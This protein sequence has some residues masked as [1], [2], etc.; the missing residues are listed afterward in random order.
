MPVNIL[1]KLRKAFVG[2]QGIVDS[3]DV[4]VNNTDLVGVL[5]GATNNQTALN[6]LDGTGIGAEIFTFTGAYSAQSTNIDEWFGGKQLVRMRCTSRGSSPTGSL[7]FDLPGTSALNTAFNQLVARGI[8]ERIEFNIEYTGATDSFVNI[9]PRVS[10]SPQ[11]MGITN[12]IVRSGVVATLEITRS[13]GTISSYIFTSISQIAAPGTGTFDALKLINP[14]TTIWDASSGG[15]LPTSGV[16]KGNAYKVSNAP[17]DGSGRFG[18]VMQN[19]DWVVWEGET[20]TDWATEPHAWFVLA[21]HDVRRITALEQDFLTDVQTTAVSDRNSVIRG[22]DYAVSAGEIRIKLYDSVANYTAEDLNTT[23][24][25]DQFTQASNATG[26]VAIRLSG[27]QSTLASVLPNLYV[28]ANEILLGNM[29]RDFTHRGDFATESDYTLDQSFNYTANS[30]I[31]VFFGE[32]VDRYNLP[33]LDVF[34]SN[35]SDTL[36][37]RIN[38]NY[39]TSEL[40]PALAALNNQADI[41]NITHTDY[42]SNNSHIYLSGT[43]SILKNQ[44]A[45]FPTTTGKFVNEIVGSSIT[46]DEPTQLTSVQDVSN[47]TNNVMTGAGISGNSFGINPFDQ[48]NWRMVIGGWMYYDTLPTSFTPILR[49]MERGSSNYRDIFGIGSAGIIFKQRATTGSTI[50]T[51]IRHPIYTDGTGAAGGLTNPSLTSGNLSVTFRIYEADSYFVQVQ[52]K[53]GGSL[54][55]GEAQTYVVTNINTS[56]AESTINFNLGAGTQTVKFQYDAASTIYGGSRH[57]ITVSVDSIIAGLDELEIDILS[58]PTSVNVSTGNTYTDVNISEGHTAARRLMRYI[59]S[60]RSVNGLE[61]GALECV[62]TFF[63]Y[64]LN[65]TPAVFDENTFNLLYPA[66]DLNWNDLV[67]AGQGIHQNVQGFFL[68][69]DTPL[70]EFPRHN[71]LRNWIA[72]YDTKTTQWCWGN[73]HGPSQDAEVVH[74]NEFVNFSNFILTSPNNTKYRLLVDNA[75]TLSTEVVT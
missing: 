15:Q 52:G 6:R 44:P 69:P 42:R 20:F 37:S 22:E 23:G 8:A 21:A 4:E 30:V 26:I 71:T 60:F 57:L 3:A 74:F 58:A 17:A 1:G 39:G 12:I 67:Y 40:P 72:N 28:Y 2:T 59:A 33:N 29:D 24:Q 66:L 19:G 47:L 43:F 49:V 25:I 63:G 16:V 50:A 10:P 31:K 5:T 62:L 34:E 9:R 61:D 11:I 55:G 27:T 65:G 70:L 14:A 56:Q 38:T 13:S 48:N 45:A 53:L 35:L 68:N 7:A 46:V 75:G 64:D 32:L 51:S 41:F 36:Q 54:Q 73:V 18:E